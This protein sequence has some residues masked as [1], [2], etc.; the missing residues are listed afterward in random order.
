[1]PSWLSK[2]CTFWS[3]TCGLRGS[4]ELKISYG[5]G[6]NTRD[7]SV[8]VRDVVLQTTTT[9]KNCAPTTTASFLR[10][11]GVGGNKDPFRALWYEHSFTKTIIIPVR[12]RAGRS[13]CEDSLCLRRC[14]D[15]NWLPKC[16]V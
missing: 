3:V 15:D 11:V 2:S 5:Q 14:M 16:V 10:C 9:T 1:M 6:G 7:A 12:V 13:R 4:L 8:W